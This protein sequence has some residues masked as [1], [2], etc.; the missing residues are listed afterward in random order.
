MVIS[1]LRRKVLYN[2][3]VRIQKIVRRKLGCRKSDRQRLRLI[4][5]ERERCNTEQVLIAREIKRLCTIEE[6]DNA[7][8]GKITANNTSFRDLMQMIY[9]ECDKILNSRKKIPA[10]DNALK[11]S[12]STDNSLPKKIMASAPPG[13][14]DIKLSDLITAAVLK[15][16]ACNGPFNDRNLCFIA[17]FIFIIKAFSNREND[18]IDSLSLSIILLSGYLKPQKNNLSSS[19]AKSF[20]HINMFSASDLSYIL[21]PTRALKIRVLVTGRLPNALV[22]RA[23]LVRK[24]TSYADEC[25]RESINAIRT[26]SKLGKL[27]KKL[28]ENTII[29]IT[30]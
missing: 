10:D 25:L 16:D 9:D 18:C 15:V 4:A 19:V 3:V 22:A 28:V 2:K 21:E 13:P 5:I 27:K 17:S 8:D 26:G 23:A 20:D 7:M 24:W 29:T 11:V 6:F 1:G 30:F 12:K 14:N